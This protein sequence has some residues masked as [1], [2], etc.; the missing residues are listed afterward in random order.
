MQKTR[1]SFSS[2]GALVCTNK[3]DG[4]C[5]CA[6]KSLKEILSRFEEKPEDLEH[7][8]NYACLLTA[9]NELKK[10][11]ATRT[12]LRCAID[13]CQ[14]S[15]DLWLALASAESFKEGR[16]VLGKALTIIP[17]SPSLWIAYAKLEE[18]NNNKNAVAAV[19]EKALT[20]LSSNNI[21]IN[22][23]DWLNEAVLAEEN[24]AIHCCKIFINSVLG[25]SVKE[26]K[27]KLVFM[28]DADLVNTVF[29]H[30]S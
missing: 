2:E 3:N 4:N 13:K 27:K 29:L 18:A 25:C 6:E 15:P 19:V 5:N 10:P 12:L 7:K 16:K 21:K 26:E 23:L 17:T 9:A 14:S 20:T 24:G 22:R 28:A 11:E 1:T 8:P 30:L